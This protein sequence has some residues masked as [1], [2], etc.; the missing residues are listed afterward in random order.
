MADLAPQ[1]IP[2]IT[3][4]V[5]VDGGVT[6]EPGTAEKIAGLVD[7]LLPKRP[8]L[9]DLDD[10]DAYPVPEDEDFIEGT[11]EH[12][13]I[14][15][16]DLEQIAR[17]LILDH[18]MIPPQ[19]FRVR[20]LWRREETGNAVGK[21]IKATGPLKHMTGADWVIWCAADTPRMGGWTLKQIRALVYHELL[22]IGMTDKGKP[23]ARKHDAEVFREE[24][25]EFGLWDDR[26]KF[27]FGQLP[28]FSESE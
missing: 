14:D 4:H 24:I 27:V 17:T 12:E 19:M 23:S 25:A 9:E 5:D 11:L 18:E 3:A 13:F 22:H 28:L 6:Y 2:T 10:A 7:A 1:G 21:T 15:A 16:P 20:Y 8:R 26:L